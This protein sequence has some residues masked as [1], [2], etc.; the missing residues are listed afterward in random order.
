HALQGLHEFGD[1]VAVE[2]EP[3]GKPNRPRDD[4]HDPRQP[5]P[6]Q[7]AHRF[8]SSAIRLSQACSHRRQP[9]SPQ[10][11]LASAQ[12]TLLAV[13]PRKLRTRRNSFPSL[14]TSR[15]GASLMSSSNGGNHSTR[16]GTSE[17]PVSR[18]PSRATGSWSALA[19]VCVA[20]E[21]SPSA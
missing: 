5:H 18:K 13:P 8:N 20:A 11:L 10:S 15:P 12:S 2:V 1:L 19:K 4:G 14:G 7:R 21:A 17:S 9:I 6:P 16:L 3:S